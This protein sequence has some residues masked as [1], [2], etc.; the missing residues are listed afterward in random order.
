[1]EQTVIMFICIIS[2]AL[3]I[4]IDKIVKANPH[5]NIEDVIQ[6]NRIIIFLTLSMIGGIIYM[7]QDDQMIKTSFGKDILMTEDFYSPE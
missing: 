2:F 7:N 3:A 4:Y 1:M 5:K 6:E